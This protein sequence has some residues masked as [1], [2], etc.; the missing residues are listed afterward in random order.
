VEDPPPRQALTGC[1]RVGSGSS[2]INL[3]FRANPEAI[4]RQELL[5]GVKYGIRAIRAEIL[6]EMKR[7]I[8]P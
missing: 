4:A 7:A 6:D 3:A 2:S 1:A 5:N 8:L